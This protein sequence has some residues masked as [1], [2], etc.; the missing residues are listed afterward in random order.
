M[1]LSMYMRVLLLAAGLVGCG[2]DGADADSIDLGPGSYAVAATQFSPEGETTLVALVEDP[3][4][5][6]DL[7]TTRALELGGS[8]ALFGPD[9]RNLFALGT[10][11][12]PT[13]TRYELTDGELVKRASLSLS[14][15]GISSAFKRPELVPF[16]SQ[17]KA[18][19]IDDASA[20]VVVW[21]PEEM[22]ISGS[23]S[24]EGAQQEGLMLEVGEAVVRGDLVFVSASYYDADDNTVPGAVLLVL[25]TARDELVDVVESDACGGES[26]LLEADGTLYAAT[27]PFSASLHALQKPAGFPAPCLL[28]VLPG[29]REFDDS[30]QIATAELTG[31]HLSGGLVRGHG[32]AAYLLALH[33]ELLAEPIGDDTDI[34]AP[35][36]ATAWRW[37]RVELGRD[38]AGEQVDD[39]PAGSAATR[40]LSAGGRDFISSTSFETGETTLLVPREDGSLTPGLKM[41]GYPYGLI[42]LH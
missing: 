25:D 16:L 26:L 10:S 34:Y 35:Y 22:S 23:F 8:A 1:K 7:D 2:D 32:G 14:D 39:V 38:A 30:F 27:D 12:G 31:G 4:R 37:W 42:Q 33:E 17:D 15:S 21:N 18:Y 28:R 5:E 36:E 9:G 11:D 29:E 24:F 13:L 41:V 6:Q 19:W 20:Q 3:S 40:V